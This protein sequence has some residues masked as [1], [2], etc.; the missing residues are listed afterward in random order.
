MCDLIA[1]YQLLYQCLL[2]RLDAMN[3]HVPAARRLHLRYLS[4]SLSLS[5][6]CGMHLPSATRL[7]IVH[8]STSWLVLL[9]LQNTPLPDCTALIAGTTF[10]Q[11]P[12][13]GI[14]LS[15]TV[16]CLP[17][18]AL[19]RFAVL[20]HVHS[21]LLPHCCVLPVMQ[22]TLPCNYAPLIAPY[23]QVPRATCQPPPAVLPLSQ[24]H[25]IVNYNFYLPEG[26]TVSTLDAAAA[27]STGPVRLGIVPTEVCR[28]VL[29]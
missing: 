15:P 28:Y 11:F 10:P 27:K 6:P 21:S 25:G 13:A 19:G 7:I 14:P 1:L 8:V 29:Q 4:L 17:I 3:L 23:Q 9:L 5:V 12:V 18:Q 26:Y 24:C 22:F 20:H 2:V 16:C